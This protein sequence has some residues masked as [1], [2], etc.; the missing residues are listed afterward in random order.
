MV[1]LLITTV[2]LVYHIFCCLL[3][4]MLVLLSFYLSVVCCIFC[5]CLFLSFFFFSSRIRHTRLF[6]DW[7]SDVCS[8]DLGSRPRPR[9]SIRCA[10]APAPPNGVPRA[11]ARSS[12]ATSPG[13]IFERGRSCRARWRP[14]LRGEPRSEERRVGKECR[15]R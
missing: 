15:S 1:R 3:L 8:S 9:N 11:R 6:S 14:C 7:S 2:S 13:R 10:S 12:R 4:V 5:C